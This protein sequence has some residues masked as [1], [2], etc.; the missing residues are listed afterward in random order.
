MLKS[1]RNS[2]CHGSSRPGAAIG[3]VQVGVT[4]KKQIPDASRINAGRCALPSGG[5]GE[6]CLRSSSLPI[7]ES[8]LRR[9]AVH[10]RIFPA[11]GKQIAIFPAAQSRMAPASAP[12]HVM[13]VDPVIDAAP[14]KTVALAPSIANKGLDLKGGAPARPRNALVMGCA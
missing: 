1:P 12:A 5:N 13:P 3:L 6:A 7:G 11:N 9:T 10:A 4:H 8:V 14:Q 2:H